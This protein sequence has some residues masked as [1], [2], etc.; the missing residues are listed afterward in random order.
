MLLGFELVWS[1]VSQVLGVWSTEQVLGDVL[2]AAVISVLDTVGTDVVLR[3]PVDWTSV[4][5]VTPEVSC[6]PPDGF[7]VV[8]ISHLGAQIVV[9]EPPFL[10]GYHLAGHVMSSDLTLSLRSYSK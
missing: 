6:P 5:G 7:V 2:A 3:Y 9:I 4:S 10:V 8:G 1:L